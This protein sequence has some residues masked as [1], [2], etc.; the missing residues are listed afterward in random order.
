MPT[1]KRA[2]RSRWSRAAW[3]ALWVVKGQPQKLSLFDL[4]T[5]PEEA[6][7]LLDGKCDA[8]DFIFAWYIGDELHGSI[9]R[10]DS[11]YGGTAYYVHG[12]DDGGNK[13]MLGGSSS[14]P[15]ACLRLWQHVKIRGA[16]AWY[17]KVVEKRARKPERYT[18][19]IRRRP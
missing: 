4:L 6:F 11:M 7:D 3:L 12:L 9:K 8:T 13:I 5:V 18:G 10:V 1:R 2:R 16:P 15:Q 19:E 14:L 17:G